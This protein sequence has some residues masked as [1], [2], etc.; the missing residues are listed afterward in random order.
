MLIEFDVAVL[1][2]GVAGSA[3]AIAA[4][5][6]GARVCVVNGRLGAS[7]MF[8]GAWRGG[9]PDGL[10]QEL[11]LSGYEL[12]SCAHPL[13][14]P[15]GA[16]IACDFAAPAHCA[17]QLTEDTL[18]VGIA[19]LPAF[20]AAAL[21]LQW[22]AHGG[23]RLA[24]A[25]IALDR[26]PAAGWA[27]ASLGALADR[28]PELI[29]NALAAVLAGHRPRRVILPPVLGL[30]SN[31][32]SHRRIQEL[33]ATTIGEAL[34]MPPSLP[35]WRLQLALRDALERARVARF[36]VAARAQERGRARIDALQ[37]ASGDVIRARTFV[38]ATGKYAA[39]GI[40]ADGVFR[41][42]ALGC[43]VWVDHLGERF[44]AAEP[45]ILTDPDRSEDQPLL[46]AGVH[47]NAEQRPVDH[48]GDVVYANVLVA[49]SIRAGWSI[50]SRAIGEAALDGWAAGERA[51]AA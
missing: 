42:P 18:V 30:R 21:A 13:P 11:A 38:L 23:I 6:H 1:G 40:A 9:C 5:R 24:A 27:P 26:T 39:G 32:T 45:L 4:A 37:L 50:A 31:A 44:T 14:H 36:D 46:R 25:T 8:S 41:E 2:G 51:V 15:T 10:R 7:A 49:G 35:G 16:L 19:G 33:T 29:A 20:E 47:T 28:S 12:L 34:G 48:L 17:A 22:S 43:P 3:A